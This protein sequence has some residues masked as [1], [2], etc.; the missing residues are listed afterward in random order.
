VGEAHTESDLESRLEVSRAQDVYLTWQYHA[1]VS[2]RYRYLTVATPKVA[3]TTVKRVLQYWQGEPDAENRNK[4]HYTGN[5]L[6]LARFDIETVARILT[7]PHWFRFCFVRNPY[8]RIFSAWKSKIGNTWDRQYDRLRDRIRVAY[9][10]PEPREGLQPMVF[11]ADF[12]RFVTESDDRGVIHDGHWERQVNVLLYD[13]FPY[14][15]IG[16][17]ESFR[18]D[19]VRLLRRLRAPDDVIIMAIEVTNPTA[20]V[21]LAAAYDDDLADRVYHYYRADFEAFGYDRDS[22]R[23]YARWAP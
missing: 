16:R 21:P 19:F 9:E 7:D 3:C 11:F 23:F 20:P 18:E 12:V 5:T 8:D 17:F 22:W 6:R 15:V 1:R 13:L 14:D 2:L 10:Y 4:V